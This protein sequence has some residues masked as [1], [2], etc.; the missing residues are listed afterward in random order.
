VTASSALL[1]F[2][3]ILL[4]VLV[5]FIAFLLWRRPVASPGPDPGLLLVQQQMTR[6]SE[7]L[8]EVSASVPKEVSTALGALLG[9]VGTRLAENA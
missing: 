1:A 4:F 6:L 3:V 9:Q 7:Q 5:G 2:V 8:A